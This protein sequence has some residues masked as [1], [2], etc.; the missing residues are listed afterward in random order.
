MCDK[1]FDLLHREKYWYITHFSTP[2]ACLCTSVKLNDLFIKYGT[3]K[4][5]HGYADIYFSYIEKLKNENINLLEIGV[6]DGKSLLA[7]SDYFKNGKIIGIDKNHIDLNE[8]NI[9]KS[10][11][12]IHQGLQGDSKF[13]QSL[14]KK[15][16][17]FDIIIDDGSHFPKDVIKSFNLLFSSL[18]E[19]GL[20]FVEDTQTSYNH[21]FK[22]NPFNL[23]YANTH[24]NFFKNL[25]D[26]LNYQ[27]I[28]NPFYKKKIY[29]SKITNISFYHNFIVVQKGIN[30]KPSNLV[31]NNSYENK[32]Y[33]EKV[34]RSGKKIMY[35]IKYKIFY[36]FYTSCL[37][38]FN[39]IKKI[40]LFRF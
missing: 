35:Y 25:T 29:D 5:Q 8:K 1:V 40:V 31:L 7:W 9:N 16:E 32:R 38:L 24:M 36:K 23:K 34:K 30:D 39:F 18:K 20:Y 2:L 19:N 26:S 14:I 13:I 27:E 10:N 37:F 15:Y 4:S 12:I 3:N 28:A 21:F 22:G 17:K 11:I 6:A 33:D